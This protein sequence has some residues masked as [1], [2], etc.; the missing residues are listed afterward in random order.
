LAPQVAQHL[1]MLTPLYISQEGLPIT[2]PSFYSKITADQ[3][4]HVFRSA[5]ST[6]I[7]LLNKRVEILNEAGG[8][9]TDH[10]QGSFSVMIKKCHHSAKRLLEL[11]TTT[12][13]GFQDEG[14][15]N[16]QRVSFY[17]R[18]QIVIADVWACFEGKTWGQFDDIEAITMFADYKVPQAL[19]HLGV[20]EY[21]EELMAKLKR[22]ELI[23]PGDR[24]EMEIRG[25]SIWSIEK[26][27]QMVLNKAKKDS[28]FCSM[29]K[30]ELTKCFNSIIIDFY[31][32]DFAKEKVETVT[33][34]P[35]HKTRT[36]FY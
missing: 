2:K 11:I 9:L 1:K 33:D 18:A 10:F 27:Y 3:L 30:H 8:I 19:L 25:N 5:T 22:G 14:I 24:L 20:L 36:I 28:K 29:P 7:P 17:K 21:S 15:F 23:P 26:I 13:K 34:L 32:W 4:K 6:E 16:N 12:L 31:L 35:C